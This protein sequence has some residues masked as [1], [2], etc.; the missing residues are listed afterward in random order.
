MSTPASVDTAAVKAL[1]TRLCSSPSTA[2]A[3]LGAALLEGGASAR[4]AAAAAYESC[5]TGDSV[6]SLFYNWVNDAD[7]KDFARVVKYATAFVEAADAL[8][9]PVCVSIAATDASGEVVQTETVHPATPAPRDSGAA[10]APSAAPSITM[11]L[12]R[13]KRHV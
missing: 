3:A 8:G 6:I 11:S 2:G 1:V 7:N 9:K 13:T 5:P 12:V 10:G 4:V